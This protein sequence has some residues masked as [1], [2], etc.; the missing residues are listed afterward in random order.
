MT[1]D[2]IYL[3]TAPDQITAEMWVELLRREDIE[4]QLSPEDAASFLG[5]SPR[6]CRL[7]VPSAQFPQARELLRG[8]GLPV[9]E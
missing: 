2:W 5:L 9:G 6:P 7:L 3:T 8:H 1:T 4:A